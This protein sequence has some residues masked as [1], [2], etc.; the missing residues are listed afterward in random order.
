MYTEEHLINN[1]SDINLNILLKMG[2]DISKYKGKNTNKKLRT[3]I[4]LNQEK[5]NKEFCIQSYNNFF[6]NNIILGKVQRVLTT[7]DDLIETVNE[8]EDKIGKDTHA[9][10]LY[11]KEYKTFSTS[12]IA[13]AYADSLRTT[14]PNWDIKVEP[15]K[16]K[17]N[18]NT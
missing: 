5:S 6:D 2:V 15:T 14:H 3:I 12:L 11:G 13:Y 7:L 10:L 8:L 17:E 4:L 1:D 18:D 9:V 16:P